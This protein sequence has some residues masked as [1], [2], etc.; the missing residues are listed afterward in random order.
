MKEGQDIFSHFAAAEYI[1]SGSKTLE[2]WDRMSVKDRACFAC[3]IQKV[4][5]ETTYRGFVFGI[6]RY[7]LKEDCRS[8]LDPYK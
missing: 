1:Y 4:D 8:P 7:F 5:W 2:L 6:R 3:N